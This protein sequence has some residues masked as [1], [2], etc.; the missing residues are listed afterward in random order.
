MIIYDFS[1]EY[2]ET[3]FRILELVRAFK[4]I[5]S[6]SL[7]N[8]TQKKEQIVTLI[9]DSGLDPLLG[10]LSFKERNITEKFFTQIIDQPAFISSDHNRIR[11]FLIDWYSA[12]KTLVSSKKN[13]VDPYLLTNN[14]L[15]ELIRS[16]GFPYP[17][18]IISKDLKIQ[19]LLS[20]IQNYKRKGSPAVFYESLKYFGLKNSVLHEWWLHRDETGVFIFKSKPIYPRRLRYRQDLILEKPYGNL[21]DPYWQLTEEKLIEI[22]ENNPDYNL[23]PS[24]TP[25]ISIT[26]EFDIGRLTPG[27]AIL[28]RLCLESYEYWMRYV[29][30]FKRDIIRTENDPLNYLGLGLVEPGE[31]VIIGDEPI[32]E[33]EGHSGKYAVKTQLGTSREWLIMSPFKNHCIKLL[34]TNTH[35]IFNGEKWVDLGILLPSEK[36]PPIP[37]PYVSPRNR[38]DLYRPITLRSFENKYNILEIML[39]IVYLFKEGEITEPTD[40]K[41][42]SYE[43]T[44]A[45]FDS[46]GPSGHP[47]NKVDDTNSFSRVYDLY[48]ELVYKRFDDRDQRDRFYRRFVR[49]FER[50]INTDYTESLYTVFKYC[51]IFLEAINPDFKN[52]LDGLLENS[53]KEVLLLEILEDFE[54]YL[55][56]SLNII[57]VP[58][59]FMI[60]GSSIYN[61]LKEP[62]DFFKPYRVRITD[63]ICS[64][65]FDDRLQNTQVEKDIFGFDLDIGLRDRVPSR[66]DELILHSVHPSLRSY[67]VGRDGSSDPNCIFDLGLN[68]AIIKIITMVIRN[69]L[70]RLEDRL[71]VVSIGEGAI[72]RTVDFVFVD[73]CPGDQRYFDSSTIL[74]SLEININYI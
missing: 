45:P 46:K 2:V 4:L 8:E 20:L 53:D 3:Y 60:F 68:E 63:L 55:M 65:A 26:S 31:A 54:L 50:N 33:F 28:N 66:L 52:D 34:T 58:F 71:N 67:L 39:A 57:D 7:S 32:G 43:G 51:D 70:T 59:T 37:S 38:N 15:D 23:F 30:D 22:I 11:R 21:T 25:F 5:I 72:K 41:Y 27:L 44:L 24:L 29:L 73:S 47:D 1:N 42:L 40:T 35:W 19:F 9:K 10:N 56:K 48:Y 6:D 61:S 62:I 18:N 17:K 36:L 12:H 74:D 64:L 16:F 13:G 49:N 69:K 14:E